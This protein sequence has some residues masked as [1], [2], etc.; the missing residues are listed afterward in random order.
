MRSKKPTNPEDPSLKVI[1]VSNSQ[2]ASMKQA[3][4]Q[5]QSITVATMKQAELVIL[6]ALQAI[7]FD[8]EIKV[9]TLA[10]PD[11][12]RAVEKSSLESQWTTKVYRNATACQVSHNHSRKESHRKPHR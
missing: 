8:E 9:L 11:K 10:T 12:N 2:V 7:H 1:P 4:S 5:S 6:R 3:T